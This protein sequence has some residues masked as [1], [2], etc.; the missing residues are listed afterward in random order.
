[1][2][3]PVRGE[4]ATSCESLRI[5]GSTANHLIIDDFVTVE[6]TCR[7][8]VGRLGF[9]QSSTNNIQT[10]HRKGRRSRIKRRLPRARFRSDSQRASPQ[11][12]DVIN[13]PRLK[14]T[15]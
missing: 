10:A 8:H 5:R 9:T 15:R 6:R 12:E 4:L 14:R 2:S 7:C 1:M 11:L 13:R 3:R